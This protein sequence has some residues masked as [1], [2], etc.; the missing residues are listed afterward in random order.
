M[1][2]RPVDCG[3]EEGARARGGEERRWGKTRLVKA[4]AA[5]ADE[6][7]EG[8]RAR[9]GTEEGEACERKWEEMRTG[10]APPAGGGPN[11]TA[12]DPIS[13]FKRGWKQIGRAHV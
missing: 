8:G 10:G 11:A 6:D 5:A 4:A 1:A 2:A 7:E 13:K 3:W 12:S 9:H